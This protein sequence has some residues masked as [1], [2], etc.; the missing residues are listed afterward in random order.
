MNSIRQF[1][2]VVIMLGCY[3]CGQAV[4][5][6]KIRVLDTAFQDRLEIITKHLSDGTQGSSYDAEIRVNG[7]RPPLQWKIREGALPEGLSLD[8]SSGRI[9]GVP[10]REGSYR[11]AIEVRDSSQTAR[12]LILSTYEIRIGE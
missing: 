7:G 8:S 10:Q 9:S 12:G 2:L 6:A 11:F 5:A 1:L 4:M 3:G